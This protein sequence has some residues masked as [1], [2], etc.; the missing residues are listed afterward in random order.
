MKTTKVI[1][2]TRCPDCPRKHEC[3]IAVLC[4][5]I[6]EGCSLQS[7]SQYVSDE[8]RK[9]SIAMQSR[10]TGKSEADIKYEL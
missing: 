6:P 8:M 10:I 5:G 7:S 3:K 4:G 1:E 9:L 2:I